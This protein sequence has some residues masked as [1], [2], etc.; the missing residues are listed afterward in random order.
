VSYD[1]AVDYGLVPGAVAAVDLSGQG[2]ALCGAK[3]REASRVSAHKLERA[4][5]RQ[6]LSTS[7]LFGCNSVEFCIELNLGPASMKQ[8]CVIHSPTLRLL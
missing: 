8:C 7:S 1:C 4:N 2:L 3:G 5:R 6:A